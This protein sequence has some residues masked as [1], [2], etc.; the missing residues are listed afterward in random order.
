MST[1]F[2]RW[3][4]VVEIEARAQDERGTLE[5]AENHVAHVVAEIAS[6]MRYLES[7]PEGVLHSALTTAS[8]RKNTRC[9]QALEG[10]KDHCKRR[11]Q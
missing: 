6:K 10:K 3:M 4:K 1:E 8:A 7:L 2:E 11:C 5:I 9:I